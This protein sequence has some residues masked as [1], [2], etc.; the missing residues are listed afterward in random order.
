MVGITRSKV[1]CYTSI[2]KRFDAAGNL[3]FW[4]FTD[5]WHTGSESYEG[6]ESNESEVDEGQWR[7]SASQED[8]EDDEESD[9]GYE[10]Y[11]S[12]ESYEMIAL[13]GDRNAGT[14]WVI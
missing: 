5:T 14:A 3:P 10:G 8:D 1:I 2:I 12:F 4:V 13:Q 11:E 6:H 7:G 9:E